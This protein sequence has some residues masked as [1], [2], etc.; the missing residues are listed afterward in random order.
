[1][2]KKNVGGFDTPGPDVVYEDY[3]KGKYTIRRTSRSLHG[4]G[5]GRAG[6]ITL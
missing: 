6:I 2:L 3:V 1:M 5:A 4:L